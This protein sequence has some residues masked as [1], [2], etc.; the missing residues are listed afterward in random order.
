MASSRETSTQWT[1]AMRSLLVVNIFNGLIVSVL[2]QAVGEGA[3]TLPATVAGTALFCVA[4]V[5][6]S[7][8]LLRK[9]LQVAAELQARSSGRRAG[10]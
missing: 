9:H 7:V 1:R 2:V 10:R 8:W 6:P 5:P 4:V 3:V